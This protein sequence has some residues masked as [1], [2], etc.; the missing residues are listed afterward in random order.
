MT[1][2]RRQ[3]A[4]FTL[5]ELLIS[6]V[7]IGVITVPLGNFVIEY[8]LNTG[9]T[10]GRLSESHDEQLAASYFAQDVANAGL[11]DA[12]LN[13]LQSVWTGSFPASSCGSSAAAADQILLLKWDNPS[14]DAATRTETKRTDSVAYVRATASN[15]T[16]LQRIY[17][18]GST[19]VSTVIVVHNL[20]STVTPAVT[21]TP[22][23]C[24]AATPPTAVNLQLA[25]AVKS[26]D[27]QAFTM[28]LSGQRRQS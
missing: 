15:E 2:P 9:A 11:R 3:D 27:A 6:V 28:T 21:C 18:Q 26:R 1:R 7:I 12:S 13:P 22:A 5:I 17:C 20:D 24:T 4:G 19:V 16:Q 23:T 25:V 14:W 10:T 8:F